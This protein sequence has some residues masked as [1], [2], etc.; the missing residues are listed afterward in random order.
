VLEVYDGQLTLGGHE[1]VVRREVAVAGSATQRA[2]GSQAGRLE[3]ETLFG[4]GRPKTRISV[5]NPSGL[6]TPDQK[7]AF[8]GR[9]ITTLFTWIKKVPA[10]SP[11]PRRT[12]CAACWR[13]SAV[14]PGTWRR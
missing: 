1:P 13:S 6:S 10:S 9:F 14:R 12:P 8:V 3:F 2:A 5:V 7:R 11:P 4:Y